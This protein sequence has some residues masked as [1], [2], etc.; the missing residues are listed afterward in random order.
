MNGRITPAIY[1]TIVIVGQLNEH[2]WHCNWNSWTNL[3]FKY[4]HLI[5]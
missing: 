2:F 1:S 3:K 5:Q 4:A